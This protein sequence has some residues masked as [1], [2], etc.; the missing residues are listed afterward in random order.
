MHYFSDLTIPI[1]NSSS[2]LMHTIML[3]VSKVLAFLLSN[4]STFKVLIV[5]SFMFLLIFTGV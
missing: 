4:L 2:L 1:I 3:S 5:T